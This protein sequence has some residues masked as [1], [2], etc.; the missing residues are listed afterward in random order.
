MKRE[1]N[2]PIF[3]FIYECTWLSHDRATHDHDRATHDHD[4]A[5]HNHHCVVF[6]YCPIPGA[7]HREEEEASRRE[8]EAEEASRREEEASCREEEASCRG[9]EGASFALVGRLVLLVVAT[10]ALVGGL[11]RFSFVRNIEVH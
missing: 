9:E 5:T 1:L 6:C 4:R 7:G 10:F 8:G 11:I 2:L 3:V